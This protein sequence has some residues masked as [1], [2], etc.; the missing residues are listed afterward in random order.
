MEFREDHIEF[1]VNRDF[2]QIFNGSFGF[3]KQN[4]KI[5]AKCLLFYVAPVAIL[6]QIVSLFYAYDIQSMSM[7]AFMDPTDMVSE[8][9]SSPYLFLIF[10]ISILQNVMLTATTLGVMMQYDQKGRDGFTHSD[11]W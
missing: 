2:G 9:F 7:G 5:L 11:V 3:L 8:A 6:L 1:N 10:L 4:F